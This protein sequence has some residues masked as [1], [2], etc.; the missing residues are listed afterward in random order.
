MHSDDKVHF[1]AED[2]QGE[3]MVDPYEAEATREEM[4]AD[5]ARLQSMHA[6][7]DFFNKGK[8]HLI[9]EIENAR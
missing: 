5:E 7:R 8:I 1:I 9:S 4:D 2:D 6:K 3:G